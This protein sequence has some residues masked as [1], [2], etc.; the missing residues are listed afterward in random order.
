MSRRTKASIN[1]LKAALYEIIEEMRPMT[2]R[3]VFYQA[4]SRGLIDKSEAE[5]KQTIGRLLTKMRKDGELP[6]HWLADNTRWMRK[7][8]T[9]DSL[10]HMLNESQKFYRRALWNDQEAYVEIWLEK[11]ALAGV[12]YDVTSEYDVPLMVTRGYPSF[13]YLASAAEAIRA[14]GK[15]TYLYYFGDHD[16]SGVDIPRHIEK[17][18]GELINPLRTST[19]IRREMAER[20]RRMGIYWEPKDVPGKAIDNYAGVGSIEFECVAVTKDQIID[21][22]L[23]TRPTKRMD[24]RAK[25][26]EGESVEVDAIHPD[27]LR[28]MVEECITRHIDEDILDRTHCIELAER[29]TLQNIIKGMAA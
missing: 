29:E 2:V 18:L 5:Y 28:Q 20:A 14:T 25:N 16:P 7:P 15:P 4:V 12:L 9:F 13:S 17:Q 1:A 3:Q 22:D 10:T 21:L 26:F 27:T 23:Q 11:D 8:D 24:T 6:W 19:A